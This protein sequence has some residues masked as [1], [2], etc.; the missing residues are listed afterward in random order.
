[1]HEPDEAIVVRPLE[2]AG[3]LEALEASEE[4]LEHHTELE[5]SEVRA[6]AEVHAEAEAH[7]IVRLAAD[8]EAKGI[9]E[10]VL[11]AVRGH[12]PERDLLAAADADA[13]EL[14]VACRRAA[15]VDRGR[16][17]AD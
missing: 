4:L 13:A 8:V 12:L 9:G 14:R 15:L 3:S 16:R 17:P 7:V 2:L 11:V 6:E 1:M 10:R 5:A